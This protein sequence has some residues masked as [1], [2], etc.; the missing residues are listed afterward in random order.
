MPASPSVAVKH[1]ARPWARLFS[2][3]HSRRCQ[4]AQIDLRLFRK[5]DR[6]WQSEAEPVIAS[7]PIIGPTGWPWFRRS[8]GHSSNARPGFSRARRTRVRPTPPADAPGVREPHSRAGTPDLPEHRAL[9]ALVAAQPD[10]LFFL[11]G[12]PGQ[13]AAQMA[14]QV[15][16]AF[17]PILRAR[18]RPRRSARHRANRTRS[19]A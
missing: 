6:G 17:R 9:P 11:A 7:A 15:R 19:T 12:G 8:P 18:H 4:R 2:R 3:P 10:P 13:G 5:H 14:A 16:S 1:Q